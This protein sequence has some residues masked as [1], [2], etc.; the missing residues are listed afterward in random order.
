M[1]Y[2]STMQRAQQFPDTHCVQR[3]VGY[4]EFG[5]E[6]TMPHGPEPRDKCNPRT[7]SAHD[8]VHV[9]LSPGGKHKPMRWFPQRQVWIPIDP[10]DMIR[11]KRLGFRADYLSS[12]GWLYVGPAA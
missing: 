6:E 3:G 7:L 8:S 1:P 12:H 5:P 2:K 9:M 4:L 10:Q 11:A